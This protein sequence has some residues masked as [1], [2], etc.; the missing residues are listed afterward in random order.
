MRSMLSIL[1]LGLLAVGCSPD[2]IDETHQGRI[3]DGDTVLEQDGSLY[4]EYTFRAA[5]G[6]K[7]VITMDSTELDPYLILLGPDGNKVGENDDVAPP[8]DTNAK[9]E[10]VAPAAGTYRVIA[11][12]YEKGQ[13]GA[14]TLRIQTAAQ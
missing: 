14:Y 10:M 4:D 6:M 11:N 1:A 12:T 7:I 9:I 5:E 8:D 2:P 3:E 13:L